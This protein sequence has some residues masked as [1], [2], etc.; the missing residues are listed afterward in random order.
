MFSRR[1]STSYYSSSRRPSAYET[2][3]RR[4][5]AYDSS[6]RDADERSSRIREERRNAS[7]DYH[8]AKF[9]LEN[10][11]GDHDE[12]RSS[13]R[14]YDSA[15]LEAVR[16]D[17]YWQERDDSARRA[18]GQ[19]TRHSEARAAEGLDDPDYLAF[20]E[21]MCGYKSTWIASPER[22]RRESRYREQPLYKRKSPSY[23][24]GYYA[25]T[26]GEGYYD[27]SGYEGKTTKRAKASR[28][29]RARTPSPVRSPSPPMRRPSTRR[30][31]GYD[32][33][34]GDSYRR[35]ATRRPTQYE[36]EDDN[37]SVDELRAQAERLRRRL[38]TFR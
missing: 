26:S 18:R 21:D 30:P 35:T 6:E 27:T 29:A 10:N 11:R 20:K 28:A 31:S 17:D 7:H 2:S 1:P 4:P 34:E 32:D 8:A 37:Y 16:D 15:R 5:S 22:H 12:Y 9:R 24:P 33:D 14:R 38:S 3:S 23:S 25:D 36:Q 13:R 19:R